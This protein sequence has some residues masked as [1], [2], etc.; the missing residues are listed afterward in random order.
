[1]ATEREVNPLCPT[2]EGAND[3]KRQKGAAIFKTF[4]FSPF[5]YAPLCAIAPCAA[6]FLP[7]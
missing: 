7:L 3:R 5:F 1:M 6:T 2:E 4:L